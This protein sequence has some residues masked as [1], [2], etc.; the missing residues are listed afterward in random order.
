[1]RKF[2]SAFAILSLV[3]M[4]PLAT[5]T[6]QKAAAERSR[7]AAELRRLVADRR[8]RQLESLT[9]LTAARR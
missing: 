1:M 8:L 9:R 6:A 2:F 5:I 7:D 4:A 3:L